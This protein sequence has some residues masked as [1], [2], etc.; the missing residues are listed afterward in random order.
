MAIRE[1]SEEELDIVSGAGWEDVA[2]IAGGIAAVGAGLS[3]TVKTGGIGG[4]FG[5]GM[6]MASG[7]GAITSGFNGLYEDWYGESS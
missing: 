4:F 2:T 5:G 6:A 1:L 3:Y 7:I